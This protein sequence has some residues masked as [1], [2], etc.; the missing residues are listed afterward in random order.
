M[1]SSSSS[2]SLSS[3]INWAI[4]STGKIA[5]DFTQCLKIVKQARII[6]VCS[7]SKQSASAF[8][9]KHQLDDAVAYDSIDTMV[10]NDKIDVIYV[11]SPHT[12][13]YTHTLQALE[14]KKHVLC[15]KPVTL[16]TQQYQHL[17][18]IAN[19]HKRFL[20]QALWTRF[21]PLTHQIQQIIKTGTIGKL[22]ALTADFGFVNDMTNE[23]LFK[24]ELGGGALLDIGIYVVN[25][26]QLLLGEDKTPTS[27][28]AH[29]VLYPEYGTDEQCTIAIQYQDRLA[30]LICTL[31][32]NTPRECVIM[33]DKGTIRIHRPHWCPTKA[34]LTLDNGETKI[35]E[36]PLPQQLEKVQFNFDNS[37]GLFYEAQH[38]TD[39]LLEGSTESLLMTHDSSL[40][41][42]K[43][44]DEVRAQIKLEYPKDLEQTKK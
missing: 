42:M 43:V 23:R 11:A 3:S 13:H 10:N 26:A 30:S 28:K 25:W 5:S 38:V 27:V 14:G 24:P 20:M 7:R 4:I 37:Q 19:Q 15:E 44:L 32:S 17:I 12:L 21:F 18:Q 29:A 9:E 34:T 1:S 33:G 41:I 2:T 16:N 40:N 36:C 39:A 22:R 6:G 8:I 31:A 35:I